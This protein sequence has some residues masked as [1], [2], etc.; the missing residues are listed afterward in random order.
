MSEYIERDK[1]LEE[2]DAWVESTGILPK[3]T[4]YY[5]ECRGCIEDVPTADVA[6]VVH[7]RWIKEQK[8]WGIFHRCSICRGSALL[9]GSEIEVFS[10]CCPHCGAKMDLE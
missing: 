6:P 4:S 8:S 7:G 10:S 9:D 3:G 2:F 5:A 1:A